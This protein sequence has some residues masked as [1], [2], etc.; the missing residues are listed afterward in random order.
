MRR[1][2]YNQWRDPMKPSQIL[3]K[4]C[5]EMK[6]D[7]PHFSPGKVRVGKKV[8]TAPFELEDENGHKKP[9][10]EH[11]ALAAL[12]SWDEI[13]KFGTKLVPEHVETRSL[14]SPEKPGIE[15]GRIELWVDMFPMD[16]PPPGPPVDISP[17]KPKR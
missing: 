6:A 16:M 12:R 2:G 7:G 5:K 17:R 10:D 3:H 15:Q 8:F 1:Y 4:L 14:F 11:V 9:T 13:P